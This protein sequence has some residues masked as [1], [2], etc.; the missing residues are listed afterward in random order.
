[1]NWARA[2]FGMLIVAVGALLLLDNL[3][4]VE[5]GEILSQWWPLALI[6]G[7]ILTFS[8]NP[9]HWVVPLLLVVGG[10]V[11][12]LRTTGV[13][14]SIGVL[15]P[16]ALIAVGLLVIF[17]NGLASSARSSDATI[18]SFNIFSGSTLSSDSKQFEGGRIGALF[19]G[20]EVDLRHAALAPGAMFDVFAAFGG[21]EIS[22]PQGWRVDIRGLP[23]FGGYENATSREG[24]APD[25]PHLR[26]DATLLFGGLEVTH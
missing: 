5:A 7:G 19:G 25:A 17:G 15:L 12:L 23:I 10:A 11:V 22:V 1:M 3:D 26:I 6:V 24:L 2:F 16:I 9:R 13:V 4:L 14:D 8:A 21:V 18:N 20:A